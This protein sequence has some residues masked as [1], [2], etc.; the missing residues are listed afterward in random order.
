MKRIAIAAAVAAFFCT[1]SWS[2]PVYTFTQISPGNQAD[3][4]FLGAAINTSGLTAWINGGTAETWNGTSISS[5]T[6]TNEQISEGQPIGLSDAGGISFS[7][8]N[9]SDF[10]GAVYSIPSGT[11][12]TFQYQSGETYAAGS[13]PGGWV[14][15]DN[16][17]A[18]GGFIWKGGSSFTQIT[19]PGSHGQIYLDGVNNAGDVVGQSSCCDSGVSFIDENGVYTTITVPGEATDD[20]QAEN[21]NNSDTVVGYA[22]NALQH[23]DG[24]VWQNGVG[25]IVDYPGATDTIIYGIN[26]SGELVGEADFGNSNDAIVFTAAIAPT[27]EPGTFYLLIGAGMIVVGRR[28]IR[29][30]T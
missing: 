4:I 19:Y 28:Y 8:F 27:P 11:T 24:F 25:T 3:N 10:I 18:A 16:A 12:T 5:Y 14:A 2:S 1:L 21:L 20:V 6:L 15:G 7:Y 22:Y 29:L 13:S 9:G 17:S 26:S 23:E 30:L